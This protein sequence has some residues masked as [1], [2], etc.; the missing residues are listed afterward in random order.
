[1]IKSV[2]S[3]IMMNVASECFEAM[4]A[5]DKIGHRTC[6]INEKQGLR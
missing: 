2:V 6:K 1:M 3:P 5:L 4:K